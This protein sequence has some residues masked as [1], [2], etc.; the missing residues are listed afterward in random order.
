MF[1]RAA[2]DPAGLPATVIVPARREQAGGG[3]EQRRL[4]G[5]VRADE[6]DDGAAPTSRSTPARATT[7]PKRFRRPARR[8]APTRPREGGSGR[9]PAR[10]GASGCDRQP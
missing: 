8:A 3:V 9:P 4:A 10:H 7:P 1:A 2:R 5:A 6:P